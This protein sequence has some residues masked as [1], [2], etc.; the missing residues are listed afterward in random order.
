MAYRTLPYF[1]IIRIADLKAEKSTGS[2]EKSSQSFPHLQKTYFL[3]LL[4]YTSKHL[5]LSPSDI[6]VHEMSL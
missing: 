6:L 3:M 5:A 1:R 2:G 4:N